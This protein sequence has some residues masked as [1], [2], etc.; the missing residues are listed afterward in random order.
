MKNYPLLPLNGDKQWQAWRKTY[1]TDINNDVH[2]LLDFTNYFLPDY[3]QVQLTIYTENNE[4][5]INGEELPYNAWYQATSDTKIRINNQEVG[6]LG[7]GYLLLSKARD[8]GGISLKKDFNNYFVQPFG[9]GSFYTFSYSSNGLIA[10]YDQ[11]AEE[12]FGLNYL[13]NFFSK[14]PRYIYWSIHQP[15]FTGQHSISVRAFNSARIENTE[16]YAISTQDFKLWTDPYQAIPMH[17]FYST[18]N[19]HEEIIIDEKRSINVTLDSDRSCQYT[20]TLKEKSS[21][22]WPNHLE[23]RFI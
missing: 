2:S 5:Y 10:T 21:K 16:K 18:D 13:F 11:Y 7:P 1:L 15:S 9:Y 6:T 14:A 12:V 3:F 23:L 20:I 19:P 4:K 17:F 22:D 8:E